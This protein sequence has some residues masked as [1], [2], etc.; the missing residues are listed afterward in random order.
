PA[1][2]KPRAIPHL[3]QLN[4]PGLVAALDSPNGWQRDIAQRLLVQ[5]YDS[6]AAKPLAMLVAK[7]PNPKV[8]LQALCTLEGL[9]DLTPAII[10]TALRDKH[11]AVREHAVRLSESLLPKSP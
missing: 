8:R 6:A 7:N 2:A 3:D 10:E 11:P 5:A 4:I 1:D 9:D